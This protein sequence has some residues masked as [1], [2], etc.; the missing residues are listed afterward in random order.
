MYLHYI[1][2][3]Q[4]GVPS[5]PVA[6][7]VNEHKNRLKKFVKALITGMF[8]VFNIPI[9]P[10]RFNMRSILFAWYLHGWVYIYIYTQGSTVKYSIFYY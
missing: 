6:S 5:G 10:S 4:I 7:N 9:Y 1:S 8:R 2:I 3:I